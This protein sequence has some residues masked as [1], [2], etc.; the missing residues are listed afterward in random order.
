MCMDN[1][2]NNC[3]DISPD[4]SSPLIMPRD[5]TRRDFL[6]ALAANI[7][8]TD[9]IQHIADWKQ[10][11]DAQ[12]KEYPKV[13][14]NT[15]AEDLIV[16]LFTNN[17]GIFYGETHDDDPGNED[18]MIKNLE[19]F[20]QAWVKVIAMEMIDSEYQFLIDAYYNDPV[21]NRQALFDYTENK[22]GRFPLIEAA[23]KVGI[24]VIGIDMKARNFWNPWWE[25]IEKEEI[26]QWWANQTNEEMKKYW[27][28]DKYIVY[29]WFMHSRGDRIGVNTILGV[30]S[31]VPINQN[32]YPKKYFALQ[33]STK[34]IPGSP[35]WGDYHRVYFES[36]SRLCTESVEYY[37]DKNPKAS[38]LYTELDTLITHYL[39]KNN[40]NLVQ[41]IHTIIN[42]LLSITEKWDIE[43]L[44]NLKEI[45]K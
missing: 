31:I 34:I 23:R 14:I 7:C 44:N 27:L 15:N 39:E 5:I 25:K 29:G 28:D 12:K 19:K 30:P 26:N 45:I 9:I 13:E 40:T 21:K 2:N 3:S 43:H 22:M 18:F 33:A 35:K 32:D 37:A 16:S 6:K 24:R 4:S 20:K 10:E 11:N 1:L 38:H 42:T 8:S 41:E 17:R 36:Y